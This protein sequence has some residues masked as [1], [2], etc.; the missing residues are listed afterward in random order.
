ML[1]DASAYTATVNELR[2][3]GDMEKLETYL[4][5]EAE[6]LRESGDFVAGVPCCCGKDEQE[7]AQEDAV[8][9]ANRI[10][11]AVSAFSDLADLYRSHGVWIKCL[12]AYDDLLHVLSDAGL[13]DT[14]AYASAFV[15]AAYACLDA[16]DY[17]RAGH[18]VDEA[19]SVL[20]K[21]GGASVLI[22]RAYD[23]KAVSWARRGF[24][25]QAH[26]SAEKAAELVGM[27]A[28]E[29]GDFMGALSNHV[30]AL[31]QMKEPDAALAL[32]DEAIVPQ[33]GAA[34]D[35]AARL[36]LM[37]LRVNVLFSCG[38]MLEAADTMAALVDG[39]RDAGVFAAELPTLAR[40]AATL[41]QRA[42]NAEKAQAFSILAAQLES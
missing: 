39:A 41:Y 18:L 35:A 2:R 15:N 24:A 29:Q 33:N 13:E 28:A 38:R 3:A 14:P 19:L 4:R 40:N 23:A 22:A 10:Q 20:E 37:N 8:F 27:C 25:Q 26:E 16:A 7:C 17:E 30:A 9:E 5:G 36:S 12:S 32:L 42:G 31:V 11:G 1:F 6:R 21:T 34:G